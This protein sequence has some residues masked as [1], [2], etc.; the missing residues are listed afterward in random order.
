[1]ANR[2]SVELNANVK[3]FVDGMNQAS[4]S[5]KQYET[6]QKKVADSAI[7]FKKELGSLRREVMNLAGGYARLD[8]AT[9][10]SDFGRQMKKQLDTAKASLADMVDL[11]GDLNQEIKNM[12]SD[13][14]GFD[15]MI[16]GLGIIGDS[17]SAAFG[18]IATFTGNTEDAKKAVT[19]FTTATSA[20]SAATK[21]Q[22]A[23]QTQSNTMMAVAK[24]QTM[25]A[26][27]A[28]KARTSSVIGATVAQKAFNVVAK[29]NPYVLLTTAVIAATGAI[30]AYVE[31]TKTAESAQDKLKREMH[32]ASIQGQKDA[33]GDITKLNLLYQATQDVNLKMEDRL[34]AVKKIK[35]EYPAY[36]GDLSNEAILAGKAADAYKEL[37]NDIIAA[38][39]ARAYEKKIEDLAKE[40]IELE[41]QIKKQEELVKEREKEREKA[42]KYGNMPGNTGA[43]ANILGESIA[44]DNAKNKLKDLQNQQDANTKSMKAYSD[45]VLNLSGN[46]NK[47]N[48]NKDKDKNT[49]GTTGGGKTGGGH[50]GGT[51]TEASEMQELQKHIKD[52]QAEYVKL[53]DLSTEEANTR[54]AAIR[55]LIQQDQQRINQLKLYEENAQGKLLGGGEVQ[56]S[57]A[58]LQVHPEISFSQKLV[59]EELNEKIEELKVNPIHIPVTTDTTDVVKDAKNTKDAWNGAASAM[60]SAG[61]ALNSIEDPGGK[62]AG[63]MAQAVASLLSGYA[64]ATVMAAQ[65]GNPWVWIAFAVA[66]LATAMTAVSQIKS[67]GSYAEGGVIGGSSYGGDRL[68]ANVNSGE[69]ILNGRQQKKLFDMLDTNS[70]P[71]YGPQNIQVEGVISGTD[72]ILVQKNTNK[73]RRRTGTQLTF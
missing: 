42:R 48:S 46:I 6:D 32:E 61:Q 52:L 49:G 10:N 71:T 47:L 43:G 3:G 50:S 19:I 28:E 40:N 33:Q 38:A 63:I 14:K 34:E 70:M 5:A 45:E 13:T 18:A 64:Q 68:I 54:K 29:A 1:M 37:T 69:M 58:E 8:D 56:T 39:K 17:A 12:A 23:L 9:K 30:W 67:A 51:K 72:L 11:Q 4:E 59:E 20:L 22:N 44:T 26:T 41:D 16:E 7:N 65:T 73:V 27:A 60:T 25:A 35:A 15:T 62:V 2:V 21:I 66:G 55:E 53:G 24:I 36:F 31:A 57:K